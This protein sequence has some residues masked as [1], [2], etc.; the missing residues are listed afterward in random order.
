MRPFRVV[1][2]A[3][4]VVLLVLAALWRP[5]IAPVLTKL[6]TSLNETV[7]F[8]GSYTGYVNQSTG[9]A[10]AT[11]QHVPLSITRHISAVPAKSTS[12]VLIVND[13]SAVSIG[14]AKSTAVAQYAVDRSSELNV[15]S[16]D[17]YAIKPG[18]VVNRS[19]TYTLGPP[20]SPDQGKSY[21]LW[22]DEIGRA[23]PMTSVP[24]SVDLDGASVQRW[25]FSLP[26]TAMIPAMVTAMG[27]PATM[28]FAAFEAELR[29][30]GLN[31]AAALRSLA[32]AL[33]AAQRTSLASLTSAPIPLR[34]FYAAQAQTLV[35]PATGAIADVEN[36]VRAYSV[37][38]DLAPLA[39]GLT[40]IL[41]AHRTSPAAATLLAAAKQLTGLQAQPV[42]TLTFH[43]TPASAAAA[44]H[45]AAHNAT[46]LGIVRVW[47]PVVLGVVGLVL[48]VLGVILMRLRRQAK[49][50]GVKAAELTGTRR[51]VT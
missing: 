32:P 27:L 48:V 9:G 16:P 11:P 33:T 41:A 7:Y 21:P 13:A 28:P 43:Q 24:G 34:Y 47:I 12:Q 44:V 3:L 23:V 10:L 18:N 46:L 15:P 25:Q 4:G 37:R 45:T 14:P 35:E 17:A 49:N 36:Y 30:K 51:A 5:L 19:G 6:P 31:L 40:L 8:T 22:I 42:Y 20:Q 26:T 1:L 29:A 38:P 50:G 39:A 2:L